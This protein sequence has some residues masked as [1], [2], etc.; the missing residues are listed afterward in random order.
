MF[1]L[2]RPSAE[3]QLRRN[4][5]SLDPLRW[6]GLWWTVP[7]LVVKWLW[8]RE[9]VPPG[10]HKMTPEKPKRT[11]WVG[12]GLEPRPQFHEKTPRERRKNET[13]EMK[14]PSRGHHEQQPARRM[15]LRHT[16]NTTS[17]SKVER[18][19]IQRRAG[20]STEKASVIKDSDTCMPTLCCQ[21]VHAGSASA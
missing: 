2:D 7:L 20:Q 3:P 5:P 21:V 12:H 18:S 9:A 4:R 6:T 14:I 16:R 13:R 17:R 15:F 11:L 10:S 8:T 1:L 19:K